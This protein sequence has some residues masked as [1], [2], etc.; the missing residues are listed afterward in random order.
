[1]GQKGAVAGKKGVF[2]YQKGAFAGRK[3]PI[4]AFGAKNRPGAEIIGEWR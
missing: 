4:N 2:S 3:K 1:M